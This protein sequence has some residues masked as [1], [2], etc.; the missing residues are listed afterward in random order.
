M[1]K[2]QEKTP[3]LIASLLQE[4]K[5]VTPRNNGCDVVALPEGYKIQEIDIEKYL[6]TPRRKTA[7]VNVEDV[8]SFLTYLEM[9]GALNTTIWVSVDYD[10]S[11]MYINAI[12]NDN[13]SAPDAA[14]WRDHT[15]KF[16]P[17][18]ANEFLTWIRS[19]KHKKSQVEFAEFIDS[20]QMDIVSAEGYPTNGD[21]LQMAL[22]FEAKQD[23]RFK[24]SVRLQSGGINMTY[25]SDDDKGTIEQMKLFEKFALGI[26]VF[27]NGDAYQLEAKLRYRHRDG[28]VFFWYE[29][30]R[31]DLVFKSACET[32]IEKI[33]A[34]CKFPVFFGRANAN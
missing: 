12:I 21:I 26:P 10:A 16:K 23:L 33:K 11:S 13:G 3:N 25:V 19:D 31:P 28:Q 32:I 18:M 17:K 9:H 2:E 24:S 27:L 20:N 1:D 14:Q 8:D 6:P 30:V 29:L 4:P 22:N 34:N 7:N 15:I 5:V